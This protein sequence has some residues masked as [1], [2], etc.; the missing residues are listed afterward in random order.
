MANLFQNN[1]KEWRALAISPDT[2]PMVDYERVMAMQIPVLLLSGGKNAG[3]FNDLIDGHLERLIPG[4]ERI[5]IPNAS[6]E[7]FLDFPEVTAKTMHEFFRQ[8]P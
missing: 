1:V 4:A 5:I 2:F 3:G 6:H 7:M 8:N